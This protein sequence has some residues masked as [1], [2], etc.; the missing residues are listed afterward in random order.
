LLGKARFKPK[1]VMPRVH[2]QSAFE[3][4]QLQRVAELAVK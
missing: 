4:K 1:Q 3:M 2:F